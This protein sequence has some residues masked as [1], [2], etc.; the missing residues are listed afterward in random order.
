M[1]D[2]NGLISVA[3]C[4]YNGELYILE[5]IQSILNQTVLPNEI[6]I[7]DDVSTDLTLELL[8]K[9]SASS[10]IPIYIY[11][12]EHNLGSTKNFEKAI[13]LC[14]GDIIFLADQDDLWQKNKV[15]IIIDYFLNNP[16]IQAVF[17][18]GDIID[19]CG[20][21]LGFTLW[22]AFGLNAHKQAMINKG[23]ALEVLLNYNVVTGATMAFRS[24][25]MKLIFPLPNLWVHDGWIALLLSAVGEIKCINK[26]L[27]KYRQH[28]RQQIGAE[29]PSNLRQE[30]RNAKQG[31]RITYL[32]TA[33]QYL[34][35]LE[36]LLSFYS[37]VNNTEKMSLITD[38]VKH[39]LR[40]E[41]IGRNL[42]RIPITAK[43]IVTLRYFR[44]S[45]GIRSFLKDLFL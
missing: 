19:E 13:N 43:E 7:C 21:N 14:K 5:Q 20:N 34:L 12:N 9:A 18:N 15:K 23:K 29:K 28:D 24:D 32:L 27:I 41:N 35:A 25:Y 44:Y 40:R 26:P 10:P 30:I 38:K 4:T 37:E 22:D 36:R 11:K 42:Q 45:K 39:M 2:K 1:K 3:L 33:Q 6:I 16:S 8:L 31:G 17:S